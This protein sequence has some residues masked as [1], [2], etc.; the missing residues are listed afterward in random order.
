M[1]AL[2][3]QIRRLAAFETVGGALVPTVLLQGETGTGKG[4]AAHVIH[5]SGARGEPVRRRQLR[6]DSRDHARGRTVRLRARRFHG[7]E[8]GNGVQGVTVLH[9]HA[10]ASARCVLEPRLV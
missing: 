10:L 9:S 3:A 5:D 4:L 7:R 2:R 8:A 6:S 1:V